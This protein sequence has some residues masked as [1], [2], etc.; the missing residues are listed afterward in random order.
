MV[1]RSPTTRTC[2]GRRTPG[3]GA[4]RSVEIVVPR[5]PT[6]ARRSRARATGRSTAAGSGRRR[7]RRGSPDGPG[8]AT[9]S[10]K[11]PRTPGEP[12]ELGVG[13]VVG[14]AGPAVDRPRTGGRRR[15]HALEAQLRVAA[16]AHERRARRAVLARAPERIVARGALE[17]VR[18]VLPREVGAG[19]RALGQHGR[20]QR[21]GRLHVGDLQLADAGGGRVQAFGHDPDAQPVDAHQPDR[22]RVPARAHRIRRPVDDD[23]RDPRPAVVVR[24]QLQVADV[25]P[26][27]EDDLEHVPVARQRAV[28]L[29]VRRLVAVER[30]ERPVL[31]ELREAG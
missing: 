20:P 1:R 5:A 18:E 14:H 13:D 2:V 6:P 22:Q 7:S 16:V 26:P 9:R 30:R 29:P 27:V 12:V 25:A 8:S 15:E 23:R 10:V 4:S 21:L 28:G 31:G 11:R 19:Q 17:Q 24:E 3:N